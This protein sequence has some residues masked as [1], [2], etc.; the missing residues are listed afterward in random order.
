MNKN[1][2]FE[3]L[4]A[5]ITDCFS[6]RDLQRQHLSG[7]GAVFELEEK[8]RKYY[9]KKFVITFC[10]ATTAIHSVCMALELKNSE[11]ITSP[12]NWGGSVAPFLLYGNNIRFTSIDPCSLNIDESN[13][14]SGITSK[15][16]VILTVD[17]HG[18]PANS[19]AIKDFSQEHDLIYIS[20]SSQSLGSYRDQKPAG[21]SADIII[22]SFS[23]GKSVF[24]GEGGAVLTNNETI[25]EKILWIS[26]H[27]SRQKSVFG[28]SQY[29]EYAP[30][31]GRMN[32]LSS[33]L[34]NET[35]YYSLKKLA[36]YQDLVFKL[37]A[38]LQL[39]SFVENTPHI[40][41]PESSTFFNF[42]LQMKASMDL[43][44]VNNYLRM[45]ES[46]F[47][48]IKSHLKLIPFDES[49][50][51]QYKRCYSITQ[52]LQKQ[53]ANINFSNWISIIQKNENLIP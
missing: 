14:E 52:N 35:F 29:N 42:S 2:P 27:P 16:K 6:N 37:I 26:Q 50:T 53:K 4:T 38:Q 21:Y 28:L 9:R 19:K 48:A 30:V 43:Q 34:L 24:G 46:I 3:T 11:I 22:L 49:F 20:D 41:S 13:L 7:A 36:I 33:I 25:Y 40:N 1:P 10:N 15:T 23:P 32:P 47:S 8:L 12:V 18:T 44:K 17:Y 39:N 31:N 45:N 51:S 5:Y